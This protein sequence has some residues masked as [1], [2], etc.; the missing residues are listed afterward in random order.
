[1]TRLSSHAASGRTYASRKR[2]LTQPSGPTPQPAPAGASSGAS[3]SASFRNGPVSNRSFENAGHSNDWAVPGTQAQAVN[4]AYSHQ[5]APSLQGVQRD[6]SIVA[7]SNTVQTSSQSE[8][9]VRPRRTVS[10]SR[11]GQSSGEPHLNGHGHMVAAEPSNTHVSEFQTSTFLPHAHNR[12]PSCGVTHADEGALTSFNAQQDRAR[13]APDA[14]RHASRGPDNSIQAQ[15]ISLQGQ[16]LSSDAQ[17]LHPSRL[18]TPREASRPPSQKLRTT[19]EEPSP[20]FQQ[21]RAISR[22]GTTG[23]RNDADPIYTRLRKFLVDAN[24]FL[25]N[26]TDAGEKVID[27]FEAFTEEHGTIG[28]LRLDILQLQKDLGK[29]LREEIAT[30]RHETMRDVED[31]VGKV[32]QTFWVS[33]VLPALETV[34][35]SVEGIES[36]LTR[37]QSAA[38][39]RNTELKLSVESLQT[40]VGEKFDK[41][42]ENLEDFSSNERRARQ[43]DFDDFRDLLLRMQ[44]RQFVDQREDHGQ[45]AQ[46]G[47]PSANR[48]RGRSQTAREYPTTVQQDQVATAS[49]AQRATVDRRNAVPT[50][51][52]APD[53]TTRI[54]EHEISDED[55]VLSSADDDAPLDQLIRERKKHVAA[56]VEENETSSGADTRSPS[57][58]LPP[59]PKRKRGLTLSVKPI[60]QH[61]DGSTLQGRPAQTNVDAGPSTTRAEPR[62]AAPSTPAQEPGSKRPQSRPRKNTNLTSDEGE[63]EASSVAEPAE[64]RAARPATGRAV[65]RG[66]QRATSV[67]NSKRKQRDD[68]ED[69]EY[70]ARIKKGEVARDAGAL[71]DRRYPRRARKQVNYG[72]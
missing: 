32:L 52:Q 10:Q 29:T 8:F 55:D 30:Q 48:S 44:I 33:K 36:N 7:K 19:V 50:L 34:K 25:Q 56:P 9:A 3:H 42:K 23:T 4:Q 63:G 17:H 67:S 27:S 22:E 68:D 5:P 11:R 69:T 53:A 26:I 49:G 14:R 66:R 57:P 12:P 58:P 60:T 39:T 62:Q 20:S 41:L 45:I 1:M 24:D 46:A 15:P 38:E 70:V 54:L 64:E 72:L 2:I 21:Q 59:P 43:R 51:A 16:P 6:F 18:P 35:R 65:S 31:I 28:D 40:Y 13:T 47:L 61:V 37:I 71:E